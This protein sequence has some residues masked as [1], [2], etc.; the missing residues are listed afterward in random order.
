MSKDFRLIKKK[1]TIA[2]AGGIHKA[3]AIKS[4]LMNGCLYG[5]ITDEEAAK[6]ILE[7]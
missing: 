3:S 6:H 2:I 4:V 7:E 5:L 1:K